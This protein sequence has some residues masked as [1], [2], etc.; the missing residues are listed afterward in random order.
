MHTFYEEDMPFK[1]YQKHTSRNQGIDT[2]L[3]IE[4]SYLF[5]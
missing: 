5:H 2:K 4:V 3:I 1:A